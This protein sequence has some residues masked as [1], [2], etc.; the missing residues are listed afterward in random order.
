MKSIYV[1][2][3]FISSLY[4]NSVIVFVHPSTIFGIAGERFFPAIQNINL[5]GFH[6]ITKASLRKNCYKEVFLPFLDK[7][8]LYFK[9]QLTSFYMFNWS[10]GIY[11]VN[12]KYI[13]AQQLFDAIFQYYTNNPNDE[14]ILIGCSHGGSVI[15]AMV[16]L[17]KKHNI[18]VHG[19]ILLGTPINDNN[20]RYALEKLPNGDYVFKKIINIYSE[21]DYI[22]R[23][24]LVFNNFKFCRR[25]LPQKKHIINYKVNFGHINLWHKLF[26]QDPF[27]IQL[28][29]LMSLFL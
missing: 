19:V 12:K 2:I 17:L 9:N 13:A 3:F 15:L 21:S 11:P 28:P 23:M 24:D 22:Q 27:V 20:R 7:Y 4:N 25:T 18:S 8:N 26:S 6:K 5:P 16:D 10:G 29:E 1:I 14:L